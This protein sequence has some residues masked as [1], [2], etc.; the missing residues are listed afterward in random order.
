MRRICLIAALSLGLLASTANAMDSDTATRIVTA[1]Y[2]DILGRDPDPGGMSTYRSKLVDEDWSEKQLRRA[3][4]NSEEYKSKKV[5][6]AVR[7]A[8][9]DVLGREPDPQG[10]KMYR[11]KMM[12]E[13]WSEKRLRQ[14]LRESREYKTKQAK[15]A[16]TRAYRDLLGREPDPQGLQHYLNLML[17]NGWNENR[18]RHDIRES[19]EYKS[20]H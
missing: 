20:R 6:P 2:R 12:D 8:Y 5:D 17:D 4:R 18:V 3:L 7:R 11:K 15:T 16:V 1:A 10:F 9:L 19:P 13:G 14:T